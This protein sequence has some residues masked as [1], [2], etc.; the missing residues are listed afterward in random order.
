M[1]E[2]QN[3]EKT[4]IREEY[5]HP[6][7]ERY[8]LWKSLMIGLLIFL[9]A[10]CAFYVVSDW[11]FKRMLDPIHQMKRMEKMMFKE[12]RAMN[13]FMQKSFNEERKFSNYINIEEFDDGYTI[14][15]NLKPFNNNEANINISTEKNTL[16][17]V[18]N[19][20]EK[21]KDMRHSLTI[22]QSY[23]FPDDVNFKEMTKKRIGDNLVIAIPKD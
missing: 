13:K 3:V 4:T 19:S 12:D 16:N 2:N 1:D 5:Y 18:A 7:C 15:V 23:I 14:T 17:I 20:D 22:N 10:F 6:T 9:G 8:S 21:N 11:H